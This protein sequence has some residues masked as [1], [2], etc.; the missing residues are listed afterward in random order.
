MN[1]GDFVS[2]K[3]NPTD[4]PGPLYGWVRGLEPHRMKVCLTDRGGELG[5]W[6]G[7]GAKEGVIF[8]EQVG[9]WEVVG[10]AAIEEC[11]QIADYYEAIT[12]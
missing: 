7:H 1:V 9:N 4:H 10:S 6:E 5:A 11:T 8:H 3:W 2:L 12:S